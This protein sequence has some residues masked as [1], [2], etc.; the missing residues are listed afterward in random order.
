MFNYNRYNYTCNNTTITNKTTRL[1]P[2][3]GTS[4]RMFLE[5]NNQTLEVINIPLN[6]VENSNGTR[7]L[8]SLMFNYIIVINNVYIIII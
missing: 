5:N 4:M 8:S 7:K 1:R 6:I 2:N 3:I